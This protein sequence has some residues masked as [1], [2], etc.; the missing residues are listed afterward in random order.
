VLSAV[1]WARRHELITYGLTGYNGG[2]LKQMQ[3][4]GL[5][6]ALDDMGMVESIHLC[7]FHWVLNDVYARINREGRHAA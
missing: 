7:V 5:H 1:E 2:Q 6:V 4:H 3:H